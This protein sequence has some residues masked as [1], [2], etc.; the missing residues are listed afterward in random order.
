MLIQD[1]AHEGSRIFIMSSVTGLAPSCPTMCAYGAS[2]HAVSTYAAGLRHEL[3]SFGVQV[4][5]WAPSI[6]DT[7]LTELSYAQVKALWDKLPKQQ[8]LM[9]GSGTS[10]AERLD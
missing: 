2:K 3:K 10:C 1:K 6:H 9:Y 8:K 4:C 7:R 5:T